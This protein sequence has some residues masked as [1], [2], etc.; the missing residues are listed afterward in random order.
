M[1]DTLEITGF[2]HPDGEV[3]FDAPSIV[4]AVLNEYADEIA[5]VFDPDKVSTIPDEQIER[6]FEYLVKKLCG[7]EAIARNTVEFENKEEFDASLAD[8]KY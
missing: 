1:S 2:V 5:A 3:E 6:G 4:K 7:S 8:T